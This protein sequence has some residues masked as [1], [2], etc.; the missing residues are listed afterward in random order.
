MERFSL[1]PAQKVVTHLSATKRKTLYFR[2]CEWQ[3]VSKNNS[4]LAG[5]WYFA[6]N[7]TPWC[8]IDIKMPF[9]DQ[10]RQRELLPKNSG[11]DVP[12]FMVGH[13]MPDVFKFEKMRKFPVSNECHL[14]T[15]HIGKAWQDIEQV[16]LSP[17]ATRCKTIYKNTYCVTQL[18]SA[19]SLWTFRR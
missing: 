9:L 1:N 2:R 13:N 16:C 19:P 11:R 17:A 8:E 7:N 5:F 4:R 18:I 15:A 12:R 6:A 10:C 3:H 14:C